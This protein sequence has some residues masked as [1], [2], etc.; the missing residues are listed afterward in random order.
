[1]AALVA[2][3]QQADI[4][5]WFKH[6]KGNLVVRARA[7]T[8]KTTT[9]VKGI[10]HAPE[11]RILLAAFNKRI[12]T[13]LTQRLTNP[14]AEAKTL[15]GVGFSCVVRNWHGTQIDEDRGYT[16][17]RAVV[18]DDVPDDV[19]GLIKKLASR[20]K[21]TCPFPESV[22]EVITEAV[23]AD[24]MPELE[25]EKNGWNV[26]FI[27]A[28]AMEAMD[29]ACRRDGTID[30]DDMIFVALRNHWV[31]GRWDL[32]VIDEAQDMNT[33]QLMLAQQS[34]KASGR[35]VVVGDDRQA[36]YGFRGADSNS[37]DRLK[38]ALNA[39]ELGLTVTYRCPRAVVAAAQELV[40][41]FMAAP[42][43]PEGLIERMVRDGMLET[44]SAGDFILSRKNA[45]LVGTCLALLR[46]GKRA[47]VEGRDV[48]RGLIAL[49]KKLRAKSIPDFLRLLGEWRERENE[50]AAALPET[51][52]ASKRE[53][54]ADTVETLIVLTEGLA[55]VAELT[56][57]VQ[58]LFADMGVDG[59]NVIVC[60]TVHKAKGLERE[61]V[62]LLEDTFGKTGS[63]EE[64]NIRY[65]AI[66]R[67]KHTLVW[68]TDP[69]LAG[70]SK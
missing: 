5:S 27:A 37:V 19:V 54:I 25:H 59:A 46:R 28:R 61:R 9:I 12:A 6:G 22:E 57:R 60:S 29:L 4:F 64:S 3:P 14:R 44:A 69:A 33:A 42:D 65:V 31:F 49:V 56:A 2:S 36:I 62:Y 53:N 50:R 26:Q 55:A 32:V 15:H 52:R 1:M 10:D 13:E 38:A 41:D 18:T 21:G 16:L 20:C 43:A 45:P 35:I 67:A 39:A 63:R 66:T 30:F 34:C 68:V 40:P 23:D 51:R 11:S 17:A 48:G 24:L 8:G 7:G 47:K 58:T 70:S